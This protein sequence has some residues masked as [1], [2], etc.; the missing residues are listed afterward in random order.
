MLRACAVLWRWSEMMVAWS[1][2]AV[3]YHSW[4]RL[5]AFCGCG[6]DGNCDVDGSAMALTDVLAMLAEAEQAFPERAFAMETLELTRL[7][8]E[9]HNNEMQNFLREQPTQNTAIDIWS[10]LRRIGTTRPRG[11]PTAI[12]MSK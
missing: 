1:P 11:E 5:V 3:A 6:C 2:V 7:L 4:W 10:A 9:G 8:C 12:P